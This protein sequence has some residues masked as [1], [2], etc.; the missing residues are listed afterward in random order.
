LKNRPFGVV[1][2]FSTSAK[3]GSVE[4]ILRKRALED[5]GSLPESMNK[6]LKNKEDNV[7]GLTIDNRKQAFPN[8]TQL[9]QSHTSTQSQHHIFGAHTQPV[10]SNFSQIV[11]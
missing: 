11:K 7:L 8:I 5:R 10:G 9:T 4:D 2:D 3:D 1:T 6:R